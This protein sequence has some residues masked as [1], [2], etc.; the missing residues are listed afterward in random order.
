MQANTNAL[1]LH[2]LVTARRDCTVTAVVSC[3]TLRYGAHT[4]T[5]HPQH[6]E[7][8]QLGHTLVVGA[9]RH[10]EDALVEGG[11]DPDLRG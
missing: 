4:N 5:V 10:G 1:A 8:L 6:G 9:A 11:G 2:E 7:H 3:E